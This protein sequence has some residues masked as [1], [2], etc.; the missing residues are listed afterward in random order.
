MKQQLRQQIKDKC[1]YKN[2]RI[3]LTAINNGGAEH[4]RSSLRCNVKSLRKV[5]GATVVLVVNKETGMSHS[6]PKT[7]RMYKLTFHRKL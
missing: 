3:C 1:E 6:Q 2:D 7:Q 4:V 5:C